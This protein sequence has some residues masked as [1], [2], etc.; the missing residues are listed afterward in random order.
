[1]SDQELAGKTAVVTGAAKGIGAAIAKVLS[2]EGALVISG[3]IEIK[4]SN[5]VADTFYLDISEEDSVKQFLMNV[6]DKYHR[7][8]ILVNN[9]GIIDASSVSDISVSQWDMVIDTNLKGTFLCS[10][11]FIE[12]MIKKGSGKIINISSMAGQIGGIKS[13]PGYTA[14]KAGIIGLTKSFARYGAPYGINVNCVCPGFIETDMT[15]GRDKPEIVPLKRLGTPVDVAN[16]VYFLA[17]SLADY[18][19]G[20]SIDV[21]GGL[22]MR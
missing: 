12:P 17:S 4:E 10:K 9:A 7:I 2:Q 11:Y 21:N 3:D 16:A 1:M 8:D 20:A 22:N 5:E 13:G 14:S 18:I 19:T 6:M 15:R